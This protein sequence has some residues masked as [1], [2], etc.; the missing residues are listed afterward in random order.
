MDTLRAD[1]VYAFRTLRKNGSITVIAVLTLAL[2]IGATTALFSVVHAVLLSP[3]PY[4][5]PDRLVHV[6]AE[7]ADQNIFEAGV[8]PADFVDLRQQTRTLEYMGVQNWHGLALTG[9]EQPRELATVLVTPGL[10]A[11]LGVEP[12]HG[13]LFAP[14]EEEPGKD[15]VVL[16]GHGFWQR[17]FGGDP[18]LVGQ[19]LNLDEV[20]YTVVGVLPPSVDFPSQGIDIYAPHTIHPQHLPRD[21]RGLTTFARLAPGVTLE[22]A[23]TELTN[24][25]AALEEQ[26]P[27]SNKGWT[28][29][30]A[31]VQENLV[32]PVRPALWALLGAT[33][34]VLLI[35]CVNVANLLLARGAARRREVAL[36]AAFGASRRRL[37]RL[38][39]TESVVLGLVGGGLGLLLALWGLDLLLAAAPNLPRVHEVGID[40]QVLLFA[41]GVSLISGLLFG[42][43]PALQ[44]SRL[45][46]NDAL[47]GN[48]RAVQGDRHGLRS[49]SALT[50]AQVALSLLLLIGAGLMLR[51][52]GKL[53]LQDPGYDAE[54]VLVLQVFAYGERYPEPARQLAFGEQVLERLRAL[55]G[56]ESAG[57][58]NA[59]PLS[60]IQGGSMPIR[61]AGRTEDEK[62]QI[63]Y[64]AVD[65]GYLRTLRMRLLKGRLLDANDRAGSP[66]VALLNQTAANRFFD[67]A[68]PLGAQIVNVYEQPITIVGV[69]NDVR[70]DG[71][72]TAPNP[73]LYV[74]FAQSTGGTMSFLAR[75]TGDPQRMLTLAQEQVWAVDPYQPIWRSFPLHDLIQ[76]STSRPRFYTI[77]TS[78]F[79]LLALVL[80]SIGLY[81]VVSYAVAQRTQEIGVR[82][83]IGARTRDVVRLVLRQCTRLVASGVVLGLVATWAATR[84]AGSLLSELLFE[85][86]ATDLTTF[87]GMTLLLMLVAYLACLVP[88][89]RATRVDPVTALRTE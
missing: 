62:E 16:L 68:D 67:G 23:E 65:P 61:F 24:L 45:D 21:N 28:L 31:S 50:V 63:G 83:A 39:L 36:R 17:Q 3:L 6:F 22:Q 47:R 52:F 13:R 27:E 42:L 74:P 44:A 78:L 57:L 14:E 72:A 43:I 48:D 25:A 30:L 15:R 73:E 77:L 8:A 58:T 12:L 4:P 70:Q 75:T 86:Q 46:L 64:N 1:L 51:S 49:R 60:V 11:Q 29:R 7:K 80:A 20:D 40:H 71:M 38:L 41:F 69:V 76:G 87:A 59:V 34:L 88:A 19:T 26:Y 56:V 84:F 79:A 81:G 37:L 82:M 10:L 9:E 89:R 32:Q 18:S 33:V 85:I 5:E 53:A 66:K 2:G 35:A 55:P 54:S